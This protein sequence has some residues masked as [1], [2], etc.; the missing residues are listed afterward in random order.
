MK[1]IPFPPQSARPAPEPPPTTTGA[2]SV[3]NRLMRR[4]H[5]WF[6]SFGSGEMKERGGLWRWRV[7]RNALAMEIALDRGFAERREIKSPGGWLTRTWGVIHERQTHAAQR[8]A[9]RTE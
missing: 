9:Q 4:L 3:E 8:A 7:R 2:W 1:I 5:E 6:E